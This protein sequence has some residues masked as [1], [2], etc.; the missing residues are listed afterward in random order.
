VYVLTSVADGVVFMVR[1][2]KPILSSIQAEVAR[3]RAA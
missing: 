1:P 2:L 3:E